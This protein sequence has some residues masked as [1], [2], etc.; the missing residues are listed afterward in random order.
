M[1]QSN[2][3]CHDGCLCSHSKG[4]SLALHPRN[5]KDTVPFES[6]LLAVAEDSQDNIILYDDWL[7]VIAVTSMLLADTER[8]SFCSVGIN[9]VSRQ[10]LIYQFDPK[11]ESQAPLIAL[12]Q[13]IGVGIGRGQGRTHG[14]GATTPN[15]VLHQRTWNW[16][17]SAWS[18]VELAHLDG[19]L[20]KFVYCATTQC[21]Y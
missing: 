3:Q 12:L 4:S 9:S 6:L 5:S 15:V 10:I 18:A 14:I 17:S 8:R 21:L 13:S 19:R 16:T 11:E 20:C 7:T 2:L 1:E